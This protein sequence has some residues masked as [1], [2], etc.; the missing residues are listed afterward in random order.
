[1][2]RG[3]Y[4]DRKTV[5][6]LTEPKVHFD[7][8]LKGFGVR[9]RPNGKKSWVIQYR[10]AGVPHRLK[11][12]DVALLT[13]DEAREQARKM[14]AKA[15][16]GTD[17]A[18]ER[19][20]DRA[21]SAKTFSK[22]IDEYLAL[23]QREVRSSSLKLSTLYLTNRKYYGPRSTAVTCPRAP[24]RSPYSRALDLPCRRESI[25]VRSSNGAS[26]TVTPT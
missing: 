9:V 22:T 14:L 21:T 18:D 8:E 12:G 13:P 2:D 1:M 26:R 23:K 25:S 11:L 17:P 4:L 19:K 3:I 15:T 7:S 10:C 16:L 20:T 24:T 5:A 6:A